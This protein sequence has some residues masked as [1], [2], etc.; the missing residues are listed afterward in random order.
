MKAM[1]S[2]G[3]G[4]KGIQGILTPFIG[5]SILAEGARISQIGGRWQ[6]GHARLNLEGQ[7]HEAGFG[8][9]PENSLILNAALHW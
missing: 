2:Y 8:E 4:L 9:A 5:H 7:H 1:L 3:L 6:L